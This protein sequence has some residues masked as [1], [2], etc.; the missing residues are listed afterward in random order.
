MRSYELKIEKEG[1]LHPL[2]DGEAPSAKDLDALG[3][4]DPMD[5]PNR[6]GAGIGLMI[7]RGTME[8]FTRTLSGN[9]EIG[10]PVVDESGKDGRFLFALKWYKG[11]LI[12]DLQQRY[13]LRFRPEESMV[14]VLIVDR[15]ER[16]SQN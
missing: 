6:R 10:R 2:K 11:D 13:G 9:L 3:V 5:D 12:A 4:N 16:P 14:D 15:I 1:K 8:E 7:F